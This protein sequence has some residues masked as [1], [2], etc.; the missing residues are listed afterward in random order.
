MKKSL[1][2]LLMTVSL[3]AT[4]SAMVACGSKKDDVVAPSVTESV[5]ADDQEKTETLEGKTAEEDLQ[6][7]VND[8]SEETSNETAEADTSVTEEEPADEPSEET[9]IAESLKE[10]I[11]EIDSM[12]AF[13]GMPWAE[14]SISQYIENKK[15]EKDPLSGKYFR[16]KCE[17]ITVGFLTTESTGET[18]LST[19]Y[20]EKVPDGSRLTFTDRSDLSQKPDKTEASAI[21]DVNDKQ[22]LNPELEGLFPWLIKYDFKDYDEIRDFFGM[23]DEEDHYSYIEYKYDDVT[24]YA[25]NRAFKIEYN[26]IGI[27]ARDDYYHVLDGEGMSGDIAYYVSIYRLK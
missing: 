14:V 23:K 2:S 18:I 16:D 10:K 12:T 4:M 9:R 19:S 7:I 17:P 25:A 21:V 27:S 6:N 13:A 5:K 20:Y 11:A 15:I 22:W 8:A 26:D 3:C 24:V 1:K